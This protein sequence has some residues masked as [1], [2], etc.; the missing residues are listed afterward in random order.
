[1]TVII[2]RACGTTL[3]ER[4]NPTWEQAWCGTWFDHP[5]APDG[6][7]TRKGT[8]LI[9]SEALKQQNAELRAERESRL[10]MPS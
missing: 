5:P 3:V 10:E 9:E 6:D 2:C 1:M 4:T 8:V 7:C